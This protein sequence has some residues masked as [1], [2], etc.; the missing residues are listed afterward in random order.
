L[1]KWRPGKIALLASADLKVGLELA[2]S[3][4][5]DEGMK[6]LTRL[7]QLQS[8]NLADTTISDK[9]LENALASFRSCGG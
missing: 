1:S 5:T 7:K 6:E 4:I 8:L 3:E 2:T 9:G